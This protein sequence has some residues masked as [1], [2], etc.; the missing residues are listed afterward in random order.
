[1]TLKKLIQED[2]KS[3]MRS[4]ETLRLSTIRLLLAAIKQKEIDEHI[5]LDEKNILDILVKMVK[6]R[7]DSAHIY[8]EAI[9]LDLAQ[10]ELDEITILQK[11]L[12]QPLSVNEVEKLIQETVNQ[13]GAESVKD[14]GKVIELLKPKLVGRIDMTIVSQMIKAALSN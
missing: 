13:L 2:M 10:K 12:P 11:Y 5:E 3:A 4:K 9:R 6:Q 8:T 14:M 1:M 7:K